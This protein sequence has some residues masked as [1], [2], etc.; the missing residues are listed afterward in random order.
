MLTYPV[1]CRTRGPDGEQDGVPDA[2]NV[3]FFVQSSH[4]SRMA[5]HAPMTV[6]E[7]STVAAAAA[8]AAVLL[9]SPV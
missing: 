9:Y 7:I 4:V 6:A 8:S 3:T 5:S 2:V 1:P